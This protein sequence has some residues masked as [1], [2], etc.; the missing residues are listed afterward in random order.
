MRLARIFDDY[1]AARGGELL[2]R[3]HVHGAAVQMNWDDS[4]GARSEEASCR[5]GAE[6]QR[7]RIDVGKS[8]PCAD[9]RNSFCGRKEGIGRDDDFVA[10]AN[11]GGAQHQFQ[12]RSAGTESH[13]VTRPYVGGELLFKALD[14]FAA[15][16]M[17]GIENAVNGCLNLRANALILCLDIDQGHAGRYAAYGNGCGIHQS[18]EGIGMGPPLGARPCSHT[19][20]SRPQALH[21]VELPLGAVMGKRSL[22]AQ[23]HIQPI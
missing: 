6:V 8:R 18:S 11:A 7:L 19:V 2:D 3:G 17:S 20:Y 13:G 10:G 22:V 4:P 9:I 16:V 15:D 23:M 12:G 21:V 5:S 14:P 1:E